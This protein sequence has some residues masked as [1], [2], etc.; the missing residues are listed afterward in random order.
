MHISGDLCDITRG[1]FVGA[2][3]SV[4]NTADLLGFSLTTA[5]MV[6]TASNRILCVQSGRADRK[7]TVMRITSLPL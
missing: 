6:L 2:A 3:L 5:C 7:A 1:L 4:S